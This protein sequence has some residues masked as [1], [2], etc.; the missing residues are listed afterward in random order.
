MA[1]APGPSSGWQ[2]AIRCACRRYA[3]AV[4]DA[5][6]RVP[7]ALIEAVE[8]AVIHEDDRLLVLDKP[9]G[10][11]VHGGSGLSFGVI[12]ALR[13]SRPSETLE[14]AH[15]LDRDT[16]G[17]LIVARRSSALADPARAAA[18]RRGAE[19]L[20]GAAGG[21]LEPRPQAHRCAAAYRPACRRRTHGQ[22]R[23]PGQAGTHRIQAD[24][25]FR[26]Q[27]VAGR[28]HPAHRPHAPDPGA[29]GALRSSGAG[30]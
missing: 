26:R 7:A 14:L 24:R 21:T 10:L 9:A 12:E 25:A 16:S 11:A 30:R 4:P 2:R 27:G 13:A 17:C 29:R 22:G 6:R 15:R 19:E 28:S 20:P 8:R 23:F 18:R 3:R 1:G 5:P